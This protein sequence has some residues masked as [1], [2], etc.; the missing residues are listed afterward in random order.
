[1]VGVDLFPEPG[2]KKWDVEDSLPPS[3]LKIEVPIVQPTK[4]QTKALKEQLKKDLETFT[5]VA[6][7]YQTSHRRAIE[8]DENYVFLLSSYV[9][10]P[11]SSI[12]WSGLG[13]GPI[14]HLLIIDHSPMRSSLQLHQHREACSILSM[15]SWY[16]RGSTNARFVMIHVNLVNPWPRFRGSWALDSSSA[17]PSISIPNSDRRL[18][19]TRISSTIQR[20]TERPMKSLALDLTKIYYWLPFRSNPP[21][22]WYC[23]QMRETSSSFSFVRT[24]LLVMTPKRFHSPFKSYFIW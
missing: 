1:M 5:Q 24:K 21:L 7:R 13:F 17:F 15:K 6:L 16:A 18:Y 12:G 20:W 22:K 11:S 10:F 9:P 23:K 4:L 3:G 19:E 8:L 14:N 2:N